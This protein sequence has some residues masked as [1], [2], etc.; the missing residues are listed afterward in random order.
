MSARAWI[1]HGLAGTLLLAALVSNVTAQTNKAPDGQLPVATIIVAPGGQPAEKPVAVVNTQPISRAELE[2]TL[3]QMGPSPV[4]LSAER[5]RQREREAM[6]LTIDQV[7]MRQ[8]LEKNSPRVESD[9]VQKRLDSLVVQLSQEGKSFRD[10]LV[11]SG[12]SDASLRNTIN[13]RI[14]W[15]KYVDEHITDNE[16]QSY[17]TAF[18]DFFDGITVKASHIVLRLAPDAPEAEKQKAMAKLNDLRSQIIA[19]KLD[20]AQAARDN[21]QCPSA[22]EGGDIGYFP[23][24]WAVE[25]P[26]AK[27]A[28]ALQVG[29]VSEVV[30]TD[31][32]LHLI[33]VTDRKKEDRPP[34]TMDFDKI[35]DSVRA[36]CIEDMRQGILGQLRKQATI[37]MNIP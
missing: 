15:E 9:D 20:F 33:K 34:E 1:M 31:F 17:Y 21:S 29:E 4:E 19:G 18:K 8:F 30:Q 14:Q 25:E 32:G 12:H 24:K 22:K 6:M 7:L 16:V 23:R 26:F 28:F 37:E 2:T 36:M 11:E 27:A 5:R 10:Y 3:R 35:K 13:M